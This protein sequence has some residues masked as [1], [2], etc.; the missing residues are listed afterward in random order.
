MG[1]GMRARGEG[2]G[3]VTIVGLL[4]VIVSVVW[5]PRKQEHALDTREAG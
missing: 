1:R 3:R 5:G 4:S 2:P